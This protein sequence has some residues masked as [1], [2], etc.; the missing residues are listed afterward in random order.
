MAIPPL[1]T[2]VESD[3]GWTKMLRRGLV[4]A[5]SRGMVSGEVGVQKEVVRRLSAS[6]STQLSPSIKSDDESRQKRIRAMMYRSKQRG[7]L[8]LDLIIG[9]WAEKML[10]KLPDSDLDEMEALLAEEN[11]DLWK[12]LSLQEPTPAALENNR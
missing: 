10:Y 6:P 7:F 1:I 5:L 4:A 3:L 11:P 2:A 9:T 12:Y 8:E